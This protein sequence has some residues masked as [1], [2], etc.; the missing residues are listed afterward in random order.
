MP[1][2]GTGT[3]PYRNFGETVPPFRASVPLFLSARSRYRCPALE[4]SVEGSAGTE[5]PL[6]EG[7]VYRDS[8][9]G[10]PLR[11][12]SGTETPD[13][14]VVMRKYAPETQ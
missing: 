3:I 8:A 9:T 7:Y 10:A 6:W 11:G 2:P 13:L 4:P 14:Y 1:G 12:P 5:T